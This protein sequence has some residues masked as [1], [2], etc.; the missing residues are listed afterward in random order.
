M[1]S[2]QQE[3]RHLLVTLTFPVIALFFRNTAA[4]PAPHTGTG[5][6]LGEPPVMVRY[7]S[8]SAAS[9]RK[10]QIPDYPSLRTEKRFGQPPGGED[11]LPDFINGFCKQI[12]VN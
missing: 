8:Y 3:L 10:K 11:K 5:W 1:G 4:A 9:H 12:L 2:S 6:S 7:M